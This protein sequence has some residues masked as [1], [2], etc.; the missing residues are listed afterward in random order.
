MI[1]ISDTNYTCLDVQVVTMY[2]GHQLKW[3]LGNCSNEYEV[4]KDYTTYDRICCLEPGKYTLI[5]KNT[6][7]PQGWKKGL[8]EILGHRYCDD[9]MSYK[10]MRS[11]QIPGRIQFLKARK[12]YS[13]NLIS[14]KISVLM[15][16]SHDVVHLILTAT[17]KTII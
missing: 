15:F 10:A 11:L 6:K 2:D 16:F 17:L 3:N 1:C 12:Y 7:K 13:M 8:I 9:F 4:Y 14:N 5:C